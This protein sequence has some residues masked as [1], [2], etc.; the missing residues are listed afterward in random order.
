SKNRV[1]LTNIERSSLNYPLAPIQVQSKERQPNVLFI[2]VDA[3]RY[4]DATPEVMPNVSKF[5]EKTV[6]FTQHMSGGN[7]TQAGIFSLFYSL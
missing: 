7:S 2:L 4:S 6:N 1:E 3:W 5:A